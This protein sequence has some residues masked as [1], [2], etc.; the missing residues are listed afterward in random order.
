MESGNF[1]WAKVLRLSIQKGGF[2][3]NTRMPDFLLLIRVFCAFEGNLIVLLGCY[4]KQRFSGGK[5]QA[6]AIVSAKNELLTFRE[7]F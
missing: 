4:D 3:F 7:G 5:R 6:S 2:P 1:A